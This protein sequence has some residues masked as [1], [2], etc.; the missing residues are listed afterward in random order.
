MVT[1]E[2]FGGSSSGTA[3]ATQAPLGTV[4]CLSNTR[5]IQL[6]FHTSVEELN[7]SAWTHANRVRRAVA[8]EIGGR[9][10]KIVP[11]VAVDAVL[12]D[13]GIDDWNKLISVKIVIL[14]VFPSVLRRARVKGFPAR[15]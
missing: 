10:F 5:V 13:R 15:C 8:G 6:S 14:G 3:N 2:G 4:K 9:E 7:C 1:V 11:L 12:A